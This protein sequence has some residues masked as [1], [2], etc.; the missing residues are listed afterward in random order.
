[1][2]NTIEQIT[3]EFVSK[4][5]ATMTT[6]VREKL[7]AAL[8]GTNGA[9]KVQALGWTKI[10]PLEPPPVEAKPAKR[11]YR[12]PKDTGTERMRKHIEDAGSRKSWKANMLA[13]M[14]ET[15]L[16]NARKF[17]MDELKAKRMRRVSRG[18]YRGV[19]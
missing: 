15:S 4:L 10:M 14:A 1:M 13:W 9:I 7:L 5:Q 2:N 8:D 19:K 18:V 3:Q 11:P 6:T 12:K 16:V 17:L